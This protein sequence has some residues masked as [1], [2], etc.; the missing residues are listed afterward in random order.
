LPGV[1]LIAAV[2]PGWSLGHETIAARTQIGTA[3][4]LISVTIVLRTNATEVV[5]PAEDSA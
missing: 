4:V 1:N 5:L 2:F 3:I